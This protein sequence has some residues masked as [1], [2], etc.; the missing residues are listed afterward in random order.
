MRCWITLQY[1]L[2]TG[3]AVLAKAGGRDGIGYSKGQ[4]AD[5]AGGC[6]DMIFARAGGTIR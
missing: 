3:A 1:R 6:R 4:H 5:Q 2:H